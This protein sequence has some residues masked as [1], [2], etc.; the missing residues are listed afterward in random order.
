[1]LQKFEPR[2]TDILADQVQEI[3]LE[4]YL[5][6]S[7]RNSDALRRLVHIFL[8]IFTLYERVIRM[9][10]TYILVKRVVIT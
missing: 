6:T 1:M 8:K 10:N 9:R 4:R 5:R 2:T 7:I 3:N